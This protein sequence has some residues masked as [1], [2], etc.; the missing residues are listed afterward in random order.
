MPGSEKCT[1]LFDIRSEAVLEVG[2]QNDLL[3]LYLLF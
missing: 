1:I 3:A 2:S